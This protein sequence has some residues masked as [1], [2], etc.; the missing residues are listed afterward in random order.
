M[1]G[2]CCGYEEFH[3]FVVNWNSPTD[4]NHRKWIEFLGLIP[5]AAKQ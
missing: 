1:G 5:W 2:W 3:C 4:S